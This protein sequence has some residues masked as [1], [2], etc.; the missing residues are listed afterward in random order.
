MPASAPRTLDG[1]FCPWCDY[2]LEGLAK[3]TLCPECGGKLSLAARALA[4]TRHATH[5]LWARLVLLASPGIGLFA[6]V[7]TFV[8]H[9]DGLVWLAWPVFL[10]LTASAFVC[11]YFGRPRP[12]RDWKR[13]A[14]LA[15]PLGIAYFA[16]VLLAA[17]IVTLLIVLLTR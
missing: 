9:H 13:A 3:P 8:L 2:A 10:T 6:G 4:E 16:A 14:L 5:K 7:A 17:S 11:L 12:R 1:D 15:V